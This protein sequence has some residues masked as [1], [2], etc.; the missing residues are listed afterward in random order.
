VLWLA[1]T[2]AQGTHTVFPPR[3][4]AVDVR[5]VTAV[6]EIH[7]LAEEAWCI[8][9]FVRD[10]RS[11]ERTLL[12]IVRGQWPRLPRL[13]V[14]HRSSNAPSR[15]FELER[16]VDPTHVANDLQRETRLLRALGIRAAVRQAVSLDLPPCP[17]G[18]ACA[19]VCH[20]VCHS[21]ANC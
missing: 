13:I 1:T 15:T 2:D 8:V 17:V 5:T 19:H 3:S 16:L 10:E 4:G 11:K 14:T 9:L 21:R 18:Q 12:S 7:S 6:E 20:P